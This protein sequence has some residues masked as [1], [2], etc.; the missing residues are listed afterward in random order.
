MRKINRYIYSSVFNATALTLLVFLAL[1]FIFTFIEQMKSVQGNYTMLEALIN[2]LLRMPNMVQVLITFSCLIGCLAGLGALAS[3]S[4]LVIVRAAGVST[5]RIVWMAL[6]PAM[7]FIVLQFLVGE[8]IAPYSEQ[9]AINRKAIAR[10]ES[11]NQSQQQLW[12]HEANEFM[13]FDAVLPNGVV[14]G[15]SR[16]QFNDQHQLVLAS[17]T[18]QASYQ[19][20]HWQEEDIAITHVEPNSTRIEKLVSR[21]WDT[22]LTP[23][24]LN[25]LV[26]NP[27]NLSI[28]SLY[29]YMNYLKGQKIEN[30]DYSLSFWQKALNPLATVSLVLIAISFIFGPLRSVTM[31]Q[32]VFTGVMIGVAFFIAQ[33][34]FGPSSL[35]FGF[36]PLFAVLIPII[37][38]VTIGVF[39]LKRS[40]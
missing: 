27:S 40:H 23:D 15:L 2:V 8:Y 22:Q 24:L 14:Y 9:M 16:Y 10:G 35:V 30:S 21:R 20:D 11:V 32:R 13:H 12:N 18:R 7:L 17:F 26:L 33:R 36:S 3:S 4:E 28:Q 38:C 1:F 29:Y 39:L 37:V 31:G 19:G 34:L 5:A 6:R 25:V